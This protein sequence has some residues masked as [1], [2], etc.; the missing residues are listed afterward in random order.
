MAPQYRDKDSEKQVEAAREQLK[1]SG[2][3]SVFDTVDAVSVQPDEDGSKPG[4]AVKGKE[5]EKKYTNV[6]PSAFSNVLLTVKNMF[7]VSA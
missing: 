3:G 6:S 1:E 7:N 5:K 4:V 2:Q